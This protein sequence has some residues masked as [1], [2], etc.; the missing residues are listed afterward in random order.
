M[1]EYANIFSPGGAALFEAN[2]TKATLDTS[3]SAAPPGLESGFST[4]PTAHAVGYDLP[5]SGLKTE[6]LRTISQANKYPHRPT[7]VKSVSASPI[8]ATLKAP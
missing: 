5:P 1:R 3:Q 2:V 8:Q 7:D 6:T 4:P